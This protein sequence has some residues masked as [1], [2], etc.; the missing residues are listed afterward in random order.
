MSARVEAA[1]NPDRPEAAVVGGQLAAYLRQLVDRGGSDLLLVSGAPPTLFVG[2]AWT[3]LD[4]EVLD[5]D[6]VAACVT[7]ILTG[8]QH[9]TL[10]QTRDLDLGLAAP[11]LGRFRVNIHYQRGALAA[12]V[13][14]I[15]P[16]PPAFDRLGLPAQIL[17]FADFPHGLVLV[18]GGAGQGKSTT[19]AALVEHMNGTRP[20]HVITIE[21]PIEFAFENRQCI[22]EQ[23]QI[24]DD[25]PSFASALR[26]VLRQ[27]PDVIFVGEMRDLETFAAALTAAETGHLVLA[28]LHTANAV[29][30]L[31]R[32]IDVFPPA[33]QPQV[34]TQLAM[35]L[36]AVLC[37]TLVRD[38]LNDGLTPATEILIGTAAVRRAI[39]ENETHLIGSMLE[40]GRNHGMHTMEQSLADLV[41]SGRVNMEEALAK[42]ADAA[43]LRRL[44]GAEAGPTPATAAAQRG[45][46]PG[47]RRAAPAWSAE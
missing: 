28:T 3:A 10:R 13:R 33:Q 39:R 27:R 22:I 4:A 26:H 43:R 6:D 23:R 14:A 12:A 42:T 16:E 20:R 30:T 24:G 45:D 47:R 1:T 8:E 9:E 46:A 40:T 35:V 41:R 32:I 2:G 38:Q 5:G 17:D 18:V 21:D 44:S 31:D 34:R 36:R 7:P 19:I 25:S 15:P 37:Q 29:Q 11:G